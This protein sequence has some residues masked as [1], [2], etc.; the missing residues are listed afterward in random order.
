[1]P[2]LLRSTL[3]LG[4]AAGCAAA[5]ALPA[6]A[7]A[8]PAPSA[9]LELVSLRAQGP[10]GLEPLLARWDRLSPGP[11]RDQLARAI[12]AVAGQRYATVSRL[13]WYTD[14]AQAQRAARA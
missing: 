14:L 4:V 1:M 10:A 8:A 7:A 6:P 13:Y 2:N 5:L 9:G 3:S 12:D 11:E